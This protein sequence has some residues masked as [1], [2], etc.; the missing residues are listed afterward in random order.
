MMELFITTTG[1]VRALY[2]ET[3]SVKALGSVR[4]T[5][6]SHVDV[7]AVGNWWA[8][9]AVSQGPVLGPFADRSAALQAEQDWLTQHV[10]CPNSC[11]FPEGATSHASTP[12]DK[13]T[14]PSVSAACSA[15]QAAT[16]DSH[17]SWEPTGIDPLQHADRPVCPARS[18]G[19]YFD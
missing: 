6:A 12:S 1:L 10:L 16:G 11:N 5:R 14:T 15:I 18:T 19:E 2:D 17:L 8:D 9:L 3:I 13:V 4:I 7:D